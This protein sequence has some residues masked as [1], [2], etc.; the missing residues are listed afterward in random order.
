MNFVP[1]SDFLIPKPGLTVV[2]G[3]GLVGCRG[4][5]AHLALDGGELTTVELSE[6]HEHELVVRLVTE[7]HL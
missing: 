6:L 7:E 3:G 2:G 1:H 4:L 5:L